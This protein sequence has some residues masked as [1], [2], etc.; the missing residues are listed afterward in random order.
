V[1]VGIVQRSDC[2]GACA[3]DARVTAISTDRTVKATRGR[4]RR[5]KQLRYFIVNSGRQEIGEGRGE[6]GSSARSLG[7]N[8]PCHQRRNGLV[9]SLPSLGS[10]HWVGGKAEVPALDTQ[11]LV[12]SQTVWNPPRSTRRTHRMDSP[13]GTQLSRRADSDSRASTNMQRAPA[14]HRHRAISSCLVAGV[15]RRARP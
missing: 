2:V 13:A 1:R 11:A 7:K 3:L 14:V 8:R 15:A 4:P 12:R 6:V 9:F 5:N 10:L